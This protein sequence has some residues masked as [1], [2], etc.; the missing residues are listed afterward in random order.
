MEHMIAYC[1]PVTFP[2]E[3][4]L[5]KVIFVSLFEVELTAASISQIQPGGTNVVLALITIEGLK[6]GVTSIKVSDDTEFG[7]QD[8]NSII[9]SVSTSS[10]QLTVP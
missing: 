9:M 6:Q 3:L 2:P 5:T 8:E 7:V 10:G 1:L 4:F